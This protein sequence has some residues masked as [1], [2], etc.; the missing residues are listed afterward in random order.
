VKLQNAV[1]VG[2]VEPHRG[3]HAL[4]SARTRDQLREIDALPSEL[5]FGQRRRGGSVDQRTAIGWRDVWV[6]VK[7]SA[8]RRLGKPLLMAYLFLA[9][10]GIVV[11]VVC[12]VI[13]HL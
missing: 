11:V 10:F 12:I 8:E 13:M 7:S 1:I 9:L 3:L 5:P 2:Q 4:V 6:V